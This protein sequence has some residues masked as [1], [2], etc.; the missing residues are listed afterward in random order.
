MPFCVNCRHYHMPDLGKEPTAAEQ[1]L[2]A[3]CRHPELAV[4]GQRSL[5]T[6][7]MEPHRHPS[8]AMTRNTS[9]CGFEGKLFEAK[10]ELPQG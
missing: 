2:F 5:I 8:C 6:G 4:L 1:G 7:Q 3:L 9:V 10:E